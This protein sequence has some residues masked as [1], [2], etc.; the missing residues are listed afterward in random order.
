MRE[1]DG[2]FELRDYPAL[3][4]ARTAMNGGTGDDSFEQLFRFIAGGNAR[5]E[6][7]AMT[8]PVFIDGPIG[9]QTSMSFGVPAETQRRGV[10]APKAS[11]IEISERPPCQIAALRFSG[12]TRESAEREAIEELR[13]WMKSRNLEA[14]GD[15]IIAY[16]DAPFIPGPLRR[17]EAMLRVR[18]EAAVQ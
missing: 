18:Q 17:N 6:K 5:D 1:K 4:V 16:Y 10:P 13:A 2:R 8:T 14:E 7:I 12:S 3:P 9:A 11:A 15:P